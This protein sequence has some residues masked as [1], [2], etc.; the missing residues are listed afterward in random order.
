MG[1]ISTELVLKREMFFLPNLEFRLKKI[2]DL[3]TQ[4]KALEEKVKKKLRI[5]LATFFFQ[6]FFLACNLIQEVGRLQFL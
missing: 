6:V 1:A 3:D 5:F 4:L 2:D